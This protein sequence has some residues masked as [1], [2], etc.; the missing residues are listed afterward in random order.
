MASILKVDSM[1]GVTSAGDITIT[2]EGGSATQ[3]LQQ[4]LAKSWVLWNQSSPTV[5][6]SLNVSSMTD[7]STGFF[8]MNIT[9]AMGSTN[10]VCHFNATVVADHAGQSLD[11]RNAAT[12]TNSSRMEVFYTENNAA[13]DSTRLNLTFLGDLA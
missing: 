3:S 8:D 9:N 12:D 6:D 4:G 2:S 13:R 7:S 10:Y 5:Y 1:Q 11:V